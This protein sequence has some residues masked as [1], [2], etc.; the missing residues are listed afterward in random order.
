MKKI[1]K[2]KIFWILLIIF[3]F[4]IVYSFINYIPYWDEAVYIN[5]GKY[6]Y[7][8]GEVSTYEYQRPPMMGIITGFFWFVGLNEILFSKIIL[9]IIFILGLFYLYKVA[10]NLKKGSGIITTLLFTSL[11]SISFFT[12]RL[13]TEIPGAC[14]SIIGYYFFMKKKYFLSGFILS[15]AFLFRYPTGLV[16]GVLAIFLFLEFIKTKTLKN[17]F[18]YSLGFSILIIPFITLNYLFIKKS[19]PFFKQIIFPF[20]SASDMVLANAYDLTTTGVKYYLNFLFTENFLLIFFILFI[21]FIIIFKK[22]RQEVILKKIHLPF[23][24]SILY[25][26]YISSIIHYEPRYFI[27]ALPFFTIISGITI[28]Y[29]IEKINYKKINIKKTIEILLILFI[30]FNFFLVITSQVYENKLTDFEKINNYYTYIQEIDPEYKDYVLIDNPVYGIYNEKH[31]IEY[32]S[33]INFAEKKISIFNPK[34][35]LFEERNYVC[36]REDDFSCFEKL[37]LFKE[38]ITTEYDLIYTE[39]FYNTNHYIYKLK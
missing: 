30:I 1:F 9:A 34:Y 22:I 6:L 19:L 32:L 5:N 37:N 3:I 25:F 14:I 24:I 7:S 28:Y 26:L 33:G 27:S 21:I 23:L 20:T 29:I 4:V 12:N 36:W 39:Y 13:L 31:K 17:I 10:E 15:L 18:K 35:I 38:K 11:S 2:N 8:L 16:F